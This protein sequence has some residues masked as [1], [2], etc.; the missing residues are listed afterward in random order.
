MSE[1]GLARESGVTARDVTE[2]RPGIWCIRVPLPFGPR[3]GT[4]VY[5]IECDR[6]YVLVDS[7]WDDDA[8]WSA[9]LDGIYRAGYDPA[10]C[11]G[12]LVTH[13]HPDHHGLS[14][15]LRER[16]GAWVAMHPDEAQVITLQ[17]SGEIRLFGNLMGVLYRAG[18]PVESLADVP[19]PSPEAVRAWLREPS[20]PDRLL[21]DGDRA[22]VP[23]REVR[24]VW[25]PGH[26]PGHLCYH[27][28]GEGLLCTGDHVLPRTTPNVSL[29]DDQQVAGL[30]DD[31]LG[32]FMASLR[33]LYELEIA[34][35]LPAHEERFPDLHGRLD[36]LLAHH[37]ERLA[38]VEEALADGSAS[39]WDIS[40][41]MPWFISW[42]EIPTTWRGAAVGE[43][44][45]HVRLLER[46]GRLHRVEAGAQEVYAL[47]G[48]EQA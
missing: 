24:A 21:A 15:R 47:D 28:S 13:G 9:L 19:D 22:D 38:V 41:R 32:A 48:A 31:P 43:V 17:R 44:R 7:G 34:E 23:G 33:R 2:V 30:E 6:G 26:T 14:A 8:C 39:I 4:L 18:A 45:A 11:Y 36:A 12:A 25:T 37:E 27:L 46:R 42:E 1:D 16:S 35:V 3:G 5:L 10:D 29:R 40:A 20:L